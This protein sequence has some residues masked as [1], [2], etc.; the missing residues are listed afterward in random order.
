MSEKEHQDISSHML[1]SVF[2]LYGEMGSP[3]PHIHTHTNV[4]SLCFNC[5]KVPAISM[6]GLSNSPLS[7]DH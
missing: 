3:P 7:T 2:Y 4:S 5:C 1:H 6:Q